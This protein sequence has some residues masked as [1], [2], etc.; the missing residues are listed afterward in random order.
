MKMEQTRYGLINVPRCMAI[1]APLFLEL[2]AS[3]IK[4]M[5]CA[6]SNLRHTN[7]YQ[8]CKSMI[9]FVRSILVLKCGRAHNPSTCWTA[10]DNALN[11]DRALIH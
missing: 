5:Q 4:T 2:A 11:L 3:S 8:H 10:Q 6:M 7:H 9:L 1:H